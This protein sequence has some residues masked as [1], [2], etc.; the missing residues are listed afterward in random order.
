MIGLRSCVCLGNCCRQPGPSCKGC[1]VSDTIRRGC[2]QCHCQASH[3]EWA[4]SCSVAWPTTVGL[5]CLP[6]AHA[7]PSSLVSSVIGDHLL[8]IN[9]LLKKITAPKSPTPIR[10][11]FLFLLLLFCCHQYCLLY[12][13]I[14]DHTGSGS[15][16]SAYLRAG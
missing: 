13:H 10:G 7:S 5:F 6:R 15:F 2:I 3:E 14:H 1:E 16:C 4:R 9:F 11:L 8:P 12:V